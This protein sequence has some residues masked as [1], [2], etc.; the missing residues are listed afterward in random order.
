[1]FEYMFYYF[2]HKLTQAFNFEVEWLVVF[3]FSNYDSTVQMSIMKNDYYNW[4]LV[5]IW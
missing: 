3:F 1:M 2:Y 5:S 4:L